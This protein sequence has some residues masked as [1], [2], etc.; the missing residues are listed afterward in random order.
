MPKA[1]RKNTTPAKRAEPDPIIKLI[2]AADEALDLY[3]SAESNLSAAQAQFRSAT[4]DL[5]RITRAMAKEEP[6]T[7]AGAMALLQYARIRTSPYVNS[8]R[9]IREDTN[10]FG[11]LNR[12]LAL[13]NRSKRAA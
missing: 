8:I 3:R 12:A 9:C 7:P 5:E 10:L 13:L 11:L 1:A 4:E 2:D 6:T